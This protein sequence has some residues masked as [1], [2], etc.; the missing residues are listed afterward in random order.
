MFTKHPDQAAVP[1]NIIERATLAFLA[2]RGTG[3]SLQS[4][5]EK[6]NALKACRTSHENQADITTLK[7]DEIRMNHHRALAHCL[8]MI[9]S[10]KPLHTIPNHALGAEMKR[11]ISK[12]V[13]C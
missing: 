8:S 7:R 12:D 2:R 9:F 3:C 1:G 5:R 4:Q 10:E 6:A 11:L 13:K